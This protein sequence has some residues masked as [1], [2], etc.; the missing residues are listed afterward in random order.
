[1]LWEESLCLPS[2]VKEA[3]MEDSL[4]DLLVLKLNETKLSSVA[5]A[6]TFVTANVPK[7]VS[8]AS[9]LLVGG[10]VDR[11]IAKLLLFSVGKPAPR[12][13]KLAKL[14]RDVK[15]A[16]KYKVPLVNLYHVGDT[17][18]VLIRIP[19]IATTD[20][21]SRAAFESV[22]TLL[23]YT[24]GVKIENMLYHMDA[25]LGDKILLEA[26]HISLLDE[27]TASAALPSGA[28][29]GEVLS[30]GKYKA[31]LPTILA[32]LHLFAK[33]QNYLRRRDPQGKE[34]V[35]VVS[36]QDL[37][38]TFNVRV[39]L[40][41]KSKSF[42]SMLVKSCLSVICSATNRVFPGGWIKSNRV[43]NEVK[44]DSGLLFK[45]GYAEKLPYLFKLTKVVNTSVTVKPDGSKTLHDQSGKENEF[46]FLEF[47]AGT[48]L[49]APFL[50]HTRSETMDSQVKK[51][52]LTCKFE[53][54]LNNFSDS[55]YHKTINSLNKAHALL[56]TCNKGN[57]KTKAVHY[58]IA[59]NEFLHL[60]AKC[61]ITDGLGGKHLNLSDLPVPIYEYCKKTFR[62]KTKA[63]RSIVESIED[64][65]METDE[66]PSKKASQPLPQANVQETPRAKPALP[67]KKKGKEI[68]RTP[69]V[70]RS[71]R[72]ASQTRGV[73]A[74]N[75]GSEWEPPRR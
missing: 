70:R 6:K 24:T 52:P 29:P 3:F 15:L 10:S 31:T 37:R 74:E 66:P 39:G 58:E 9:A 20:V 2:A 41:D 51:D 49:S 55:K 25:D 50:D 72:A 57:S 71:S 33:K 23:H 68:K 1:M 4:V 56:I 45:L 63:K 28:F 67:R 73:P 46:S 32:T 54:T 62:F 53:R 26:N 34:E 42:G 38:S 64:T 16:D 5:D 17:L 7:L 35:K 14:V 59:R 65:A 44:S 40:T 12:D 8:G 48:V 27:L 61:P 75:L 60:S 36:T 13:G 30:I 18:K 47:R 43:L 69:A 19:V 22:L 11:I 21:A